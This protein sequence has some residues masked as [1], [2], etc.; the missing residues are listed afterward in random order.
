MTSYADSEVETDDEGETMLDSTTGSLVRVETGSGL[1]GSTGRGSGD[2]CAYELGREW[3]EIGG[4][5]LNG[6]IPG[7]V[8]VGEVQS[9]PVTSQARNTT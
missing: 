2:G 3:N 9:I 7:R 6:D 8:E 1:K 4:G 5:S